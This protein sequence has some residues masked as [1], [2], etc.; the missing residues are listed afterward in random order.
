[1]KP[2]FDKLTDRDLKEIIELGISYNYLTKD[3]RGDRDNMIDFL[4]DLDN[5]ILEQLY[6][7]WIN[8]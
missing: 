5:T 2:N 8:E 3:A 1:M 4:Y 7:K 6:L